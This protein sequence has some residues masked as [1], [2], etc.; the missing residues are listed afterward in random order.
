VLVV[1]DNRDA[2]DSLATLLELSGHEVRRAYDGLTAV[3]IAT[4]LRPDLVPLDIGLPLL[5]GYEAARRIRQT[6]GR[7]V[8]LVAV[9]GWGQE[10]AR[11]RSSDSGF[12][13]HLVKPVELATVN[14]LLEET[15][16]RC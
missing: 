9:T 11:Q 6:S 16:D 8:K 12:D 15:A 3:E 7:R 13:E 2:A 1:D 4:R 10:E 14:M 5:N